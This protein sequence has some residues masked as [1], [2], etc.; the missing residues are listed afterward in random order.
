MIVNVINNFDVDFIMPISMIDI[1]M[2]RSHKRDGILTEKFWF[3]TNNFRHN[4]YKTTTLETSN[5]LKSNEGESSIDDKYHE[6]YIY[7]ILEGK[8][9]INFKGILPLIEE[10]MAMKCY[11]KEDVNMIRMYM[12]FLLERAKGEI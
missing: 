10:Y 5:F 9:D 3:K 2:D 11:N 8:N 6:L 4:S 7:E 12:N 1:N